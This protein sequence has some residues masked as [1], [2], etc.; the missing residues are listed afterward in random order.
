[1]EDRIAASSTGLP[2]RAVGRWWRPETAPKSATEE[3]FVTLLI[4]KIGCFFIIIILKKTSFLLCLVEEI[5]I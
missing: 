1:V 2:L 5:S 4:L 3:M